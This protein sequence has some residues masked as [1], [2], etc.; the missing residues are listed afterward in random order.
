MKSK[1]KKFTAFLAAFTICG[2]ILPNFG[3]ETF[4]INWYTTALAEETAGVSQ[5]NQEPINGW[6]VGDRVIYNNGTEDFECLVASSTENSA[7]LISIKGWDPPEG[8]GVFGYE[9]QVADL[10]SKGAR[11]PKFAEYQI[12]SDS[13]IITS[14][15]YHNYN[16][17]EYDICWFSGGKWYYQTGYGKYDD[18]EY[19]A[20]FDISRN[21]IKTVSD[22]LVKTSASPALST[23]KGKDFTWFGDCEIE[24]SYYKSDKEKLDT[25]PTDPGDYYV[26]VSVP[27]VRVSENGT[28]IIYE[29]SVSDYISFTIIHDLIYTAAKQETCTEEGNTDYWHCSQC[30]KYFSD[31]NG[32]NEIAQADT[33]IPTLDHNLTTTNEKAV[34]CTEDG[35]ILYYYC[36]NCNKYF[37][38]ENGINEITQA[39]TVISAL[40]HSI[41]P[42]TE[43][44]STCTENGNIFYC[45]CSKC[46]K[47]FTDWKCETEISL[48]D[49]IIES[50]GHNFNTEYSYD[51]QSH[52]KQCTNGCGKVDENSSHTVESG[53]CTVCGVS[54][55]YINSAY[56]VNGDMNFRLNP[57]LG[58][59]DENASLEQNGYQWNADTKTLTL[60]NI[61]ID[62][63]L[64]LPYDG[65][66]NTI[67]IADGATAVVLGNITF[68]P[69]QTSL[70]VMG[71]G[72][73][74]AGFDNGNVGSNDILTI[75]G[76]TVISD[77]MM[78]ATDGGI[79]IKGGKLDVSE[80]IFTDK[81]TMDDTAELGIDIN[82]GIGNYGHLEYGFADLAHHI[83]QGYK[84]E[85]VDGSIYIIPE[86]ASL[87]FNTETYMYEV[88]DEKGS[89]VSGKVSV[90]GSSEVTHTYTVGGICTDC[91][92]LENGKDGFK[93][94][95]VTLTDGIRVNYY[96]MLTENAL[97]DTGAYINFT[98]EHGL[99]RKI[100]LSQGVLDN[101]GR[102]KFVLDLIPDCMADEITASVIYSNNTNGRSVKYS[103]TQYAKNLS[104]SDNEM[105]ISLLNATLNYGATVQ[106]YTGHNINNPANAD[107]TEIYDD[108]V[109]ISDDY[110]M[111]LSGTANGIKV[112][113]AMLVVNSLTS[114]KV[115]YQLE[116]GYN[117]NDYTFTCDG[118]VLQAQKSGD[119]YYVSVTGITPDQLNHMFEISVTDKDGN[120]RT[121]RYS[122]LTYAKSV[123]ESG[124]YTEELTSMMKALYYYNKAALE[125]I[126]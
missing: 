7:V 73:L 59:W 66:L 15:I 46:N 63:Y 90:D 77:S 47:Y 113:G 17:Q 12:L 61:C 69:Y 122:A 42:T 26:Q 29:A 9:N 45:H 49:T 11:M 116:E 101:N 28:P 16:C 62:G 24:L 89:P 70:T 4:N 52:W 13:G 125:Y 43:K 76:V 102:Y 83:P 110:I 105:L 51:R 84:I 53:N 2:T 88:Q 23:I 48:A 87:V 54:E 67:V 119:C 20:G 5:N 36:S 14:N 96:L 104:S 50:I 115:K 75:N 117:I 85:K 60:G 30:N 65:G 79:A 64:I 22:S 80:Y 44:A 1:F 91:G 124:I 99:D 120:I 98:T 56:T 18:S 10:A 57:D 123:I 40:G 81:L 41:T 55:D 97:N 111:T 78:W 82:A 6:K 68:S 72:T 32:I 37:S 33:V 35:N 74:K 86:N 92:S 34:T 103:V 25:A 31:E 114:I 21:V 107:V 71:N 95:S 58:N 106:Q 93:S 112:N 38:D 94:V 39:D 3:N 27:L 118:E 100:P 121:L 8:T 109:S 126:Y 19:H 108:N